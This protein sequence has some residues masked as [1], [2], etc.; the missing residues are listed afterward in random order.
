MDADTALYDLDVPSGFT[1]GLSLSPHETVE[2]VSS[3]SDT[4]LDK[5]LDD[6][7]VTEGLLLI[8]VLFLFLSQL[9]RIVKEGFHWL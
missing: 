5:P 4:F 3:V 9:I 7:T 1:F 6:Y 2:T 8:I